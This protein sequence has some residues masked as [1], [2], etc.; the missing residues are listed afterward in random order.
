MFSFNFRGTFHHDSHGRQVPAS[1]GTG[2]NNRR[3]PTTATN[4]TLKVERL[5][6]LPSWDILIRGTIR[7]LRECVMLCPCPWELHVYVYCVATAHVRIPET[8]VH[9]AASNAT[10]YEV[11]KLILT[12]LIVHQRCSLNLMYLNES[13]ESVAYTI[14]TP[15]HPLN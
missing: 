12:L 7:R 15:F 1:C 8:L 6:P 4:T 14:M 5:E 13:S 3:T 10:C 11:A 2:A 9:P